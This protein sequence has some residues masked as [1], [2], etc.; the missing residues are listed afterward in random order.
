VP[1]QNYLIHFVQGVAVTCQ[2]LIV[3]RTDDQRAE[4]QGL[5]N[6]IIVLAGQRR[7]LCSGSGSIS[8]STPSS[9]TQTEVETRQSQHSMSASC[10]VLASVKVDYVLHAQ[11][12]EGGILSVRSSVQFVKYPVSG[13]D[14]EVG[15]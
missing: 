5:L 13:S 15:N 3:S 2:T 1:S 9:T 4:C 6:D 11:W 14:S 8:H 12:R 7:P 10:P